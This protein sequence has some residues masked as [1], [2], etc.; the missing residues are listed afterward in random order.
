MDIPS[1]HHIARLAQSRNLI[2]F[3]ALG[4]PC[5]QLNN[6]RELRIKKWLYRAVMPGI[7]VFGFCCC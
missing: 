5:T 6:H 3:F 7:A 2:F 1:C 4:L